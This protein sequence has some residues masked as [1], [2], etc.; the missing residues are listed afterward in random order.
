MWVVTF[1]QRFERIE[2]GFH[3]GKAMK[4]LKEL[5]EF[6]NE[7]LVEARRAWKRVFKAGRPV[8]KRWYR[9]TSGPK[10]G[11]MVSTPRV[12]ATRKDPKKVRRGRV[13]ARRRKAVRIRKSKVTG[14]TATHRMLVKMNKRLSAPVVQRAD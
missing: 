8:L 14:R 1:Y 11:K 4:L 10:K 13:I 5:N 6:N 2:E 3:N 12:C 7:Q 9:C